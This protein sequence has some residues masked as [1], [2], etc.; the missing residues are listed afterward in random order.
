MILERK[1]PED[2]GM[3]SERLAMAD[4]AIETGIE[5]GA[6]PGAVTIVTSKG[7]VVWHKAYGYLNPEDGRRAEPDSIYDLASMTKPMSAGVAMAAL[8]EDGRAH[9]EQTVKAFFPEREIGRIGNASLKHLLTHTSGISAWTDMYS[10]GQGK[11]EILDTLF[12]LSVKRPPGVAYEY[13]CLGYILLCFIIERITDMPLDRYLKERIY[14]PLGAEITGYNPPSDLHPRIAATGCCP[15]RKGKT[16][17]GEVHDGNAFGMGG[18]SGNAGLFSTAEEAALF[19]NMLLYKG[20]FMGKRVLSPLATNLMRNRQIPPTVG[21]QSYGCFMWPNLTFG[22]GDLFPPE[23]FG[24]TGYTGTGVVV[25]PVHEVVSII[26]SNRALWDDRPSDNFFIM[27]RCYHNAV[28][29]AII[30]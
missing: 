2:A 23:S 15:Y 20:A 21:G 17:V 19:W 24:H 9:L 10:K 13:S 6:A 8:V 11:A 7:Y 26:L 16:L 4:Q 30:E 5:R 3:L 14:R 18:V 1:R 25:D 12:S 22:H 29:S 28:A 27:R